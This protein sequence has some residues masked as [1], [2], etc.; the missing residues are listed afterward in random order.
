MDIYLRAVANKGTRRKSLY[1][2]ME[3]PFN[4]IAASLSPNEYNA[5]TQRSKHFILSSD[6]HTHSVYRVQILL[7]S[8]FVLF[9]ML[10]NKEVEDTV[11]EES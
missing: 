7:W 10:Y 6:R 9:E 8:P 5:R 3:L 11:L 1:E 4:S 2:N